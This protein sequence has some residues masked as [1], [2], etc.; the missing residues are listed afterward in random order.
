VVLSLLFRIGE[1]LM[2][3]TTQ[4]E[5][6]ASFLIRSFIHN[7]TNT[8]QQTTFQCEANPMT[9]SPADVAM[10]LLLIKNLFELR[11]HKKCVHI[12]KEYRLKYPDNQSVIF[13][14]YYS[15]WRNGLIR[16]EEEIYENEQSNK[17][18]S[19]PEIQVLDR[20]LH[21]LYL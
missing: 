13:Y 4:S 15:I 11:E 1:L 18:P 10:V 2:G 5:I 12:L 17:I 16:K 20:E 8:E 14:Y 9:E 7:N 3:I 21:K 6:E 19:H